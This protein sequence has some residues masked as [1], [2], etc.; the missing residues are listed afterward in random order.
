MA[1]AP[2]REPTL[3]DVLPKIDELSDELNLTINSAITNKQHHG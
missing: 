3:N 1:T 2:D